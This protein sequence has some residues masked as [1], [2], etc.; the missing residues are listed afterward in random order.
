MKK[1]EWLNRH[2]WWRGRCQSC[3]QVPATNDKSTRCT[4]S[5]IYFGKELCMLRIDLLPIIRSLDTVFTAIIICHASYVD[6]LQERSGRNCSSILTSLASQETVKCI[7][8][9][10]RNPKSSEDHGSSKIWYSY[11]GWWRLG[12]SEK[13]KCVNFKHLPAFRRAVVPL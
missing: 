12:F 13:W 9:T 11:S 2:P 3:N 8:T 1:M 7:V 5:Q 10:T 4:I 6:S